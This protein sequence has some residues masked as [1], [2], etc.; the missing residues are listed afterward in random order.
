[1]NLG[2]TVNVSENISCDQQEFVL[3]V[4]SAPSKMKFRGKMVEIICIQQFTKVVATVAKVAKIVALRLSPSHLFLVLNEQVVNGGT[5]MWC[6]LSQ[7]HFFNEYN[8]EGVS[9]ENNEIYLELTIE[10]LLRALKSA[11]SAKS[12]KIKLTKKRVPCLTIEVE[13]PSL[14][15]ASR[16]V[17]H[18]VPVAV[19]PRRLWDEFQEP[20]M[21]DFDTVSASREGEMT[22]TVETDLVTVK[23]YFKDLDMSVE[24][25]NVQSQS[26]SSDCLPWVEARVDIRKLSQFLVGQQVNPLRVICNIVHNRMIHFFLLHD[27]LSLQYFLPCIAS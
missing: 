2:R 22:L 17:I 15:S 6:S 26:N 12:L 1:M 27:D 10:N 21:P 14:V 3:V 18:D 11:H 9:A 19:I 7:D 13:L 20:E 5:S 8:M 25:K 23:T 24:G 16:I 4:L